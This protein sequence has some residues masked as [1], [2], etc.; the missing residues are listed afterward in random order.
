MKFYNLRRSSQQ[1]GVEGV[2]LIL[3]AIP[4]IFAGKPEVWWQSIAAAS[5]S[6]LWLIAAWLILKQTENGKLLAGAAATTCLISLAPAMLADPATFLLATSVYLLA[7]YGLAN[8]KITTISLHRTTDDAELGLQRTRWAA[9]TLVGISLAG[10]L[11]IKVPTATSNWSL[12]I[13]AALAQLLSVIWSIYQQSNF[14]KL[15]SILINSLLLI[16][17]FYLAKHGLTWLGSLIIGGTLLVFMP[18]SAAQ[19]EVS[20]WLDILINHPARATLVTFLLLCLL[21]SFLLFMPQASSGREISLTDAAF[22]AVSAVCV[23]GLIVLDTPHDF[24]LTGQAFILLLIQL[25]GLGIMTVTA[26]A[27]HALGR[28]I[29]LKQAKLLNT[30]INADHFTLIDSVKQIIG[31]TL[32]AELIGALLLA[33]LF[34]RSGIDGSNS[35]WKGFFTSI[36]AFCNAGFALQSDSLIS[37]QNDPLILHTVALLIIVGGLAPSVVLMLPAWFKDRPFPVAP[38]IALLTTLA[39]L[40]SGW[41][42]YL[43]FEWNNSLDHLSIIDRL[44]NAWFQSVTLRTAGFNSVAIENVLGPTFIVMLCLMFIGGSPGGTAGGIKTTTFGVLI[45]TFWACVLGYEEVAIDNRKVMHETIFKSITTVVAGMAVL[46]AIILMLEVT[47]TA[48]SRDLIFEATSALGTVGLSFGATTKLDSIGKIIIM[49]AMFA[50]RIGPV[51]LF[52]LLSRE[53]HSNAANYLE[54]RINLT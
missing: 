37:F 18:Q 23:T 41:L 52:A 10:F 31:F 14:H 32:V 44:H 2:L 20:N 36:S 35:I 13:T 21:G 50:G 49:L 30:T 42:F 7:L 5:A 9:W 47:Q 6:L 34:Y 24:S 22:T 12:L 33:A 17:A 45:A 39:L 38:R 8:L 25:G 26:L 54:A 1:T 40:F 4:F 53:R 28:R 46:L 29:S 3:A 43:V 11:I 48:G 16:A 27:L 15:F 19:T 51:T